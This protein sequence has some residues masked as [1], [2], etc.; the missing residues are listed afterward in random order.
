MRPKHLKFPFAWEE[1]KPCVHEGILIV[2]KY[3]TQHRQWQEIEALF[4]KEKEIMVEFCS[5]NGDWVIEKAKKNPQ[6]YWIAVEM[7]FERVRKIWSKKHNYKISNLLIICGE[8]LTFTKYYLPK[9]CIQ[10]AYV[11]FPDPWPKRRQAKHRLIQAPFIEELTRVMKWGSK[12]TFV[13]DDPCYSMQMIETMFHF[14]KWESCFKNPYYTH[15]LEN[16]G[17]SWFETL[18]R[19]KGRNFYYMQFI[20]KRCNSFD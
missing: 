11:N 3:Y 15:T 9:E 19:K 20:Y 5:G 14:P 13:T 2:P 8:A 6:Q 12:V 10:E 4:P 17:S 16:Y 18:W 7:L 1:R